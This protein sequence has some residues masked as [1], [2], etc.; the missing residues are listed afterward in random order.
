MGMRGKKTRKKAK[1][2]DVED[3]FRRALQREA[4]K[5]QELTDLEYQELY[6]LLGAQVQAAEAAAKAVRLKPPRRQPPTVNLLKALSLRPESPREVGEGFLKKYWGRIL[7]N[8]C[9]WWSK[10]KDKVPEKRIALELGLAVAPALPAQLRLAAPI[11]A[12]TSTILLK[13]GLDELCESMPES[14]PGV[15]AEERVEEVGE[16]KVEE[17]AEEGAEQPEEAEPS[18]EAE[19]AESGWG[20]EIL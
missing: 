3:A 10:N 7:R 4:K 17:A 20:S 14:P 18:G 2:A 6:A 15:V 16:E 8:A 9:R 1:K 11:A 5:A 12:L 19:A 13:Q